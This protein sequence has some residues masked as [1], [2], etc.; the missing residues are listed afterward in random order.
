M[1]TI[2]TGQLSW[3]ANER[4]SDRYGVIRLY[5]NASPNLPYQDG[6]APIDYD[7]LI[8]QKGSLIATIIETRD[9]EH[10]GDLF[11]GFFP[12]TPNVGEQIDLGDG[13]FFTDEQDGIEYFGLRPDDGRNVFWLTPQNLYRAHQQT[14]KVTFVPRN[15]EPR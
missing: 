5:N 13:E 15:Q 12:V 9:S 10:I 14:V 1:K 8:G 4:I 2:G 3:P 6:G 11:H 7:G